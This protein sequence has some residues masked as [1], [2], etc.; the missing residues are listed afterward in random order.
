[1]SPLPTRE[2]AEAAGKG[3]LEARCERCP[4]PSPEGPGRDPPPSLLT[5]TLPLNPR[6]DEG[7]AVV[8]FGIAVAEKPLAAMAA[9]AP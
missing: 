6:V 5:T 7:P 3:A 1:M 9:E 2:A 8:E 4:C